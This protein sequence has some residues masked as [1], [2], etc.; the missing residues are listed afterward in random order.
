MVWSEVSNNLASF[1]A[2]VT[3]DGDFT[4]DALVKVGDDE[5]AFSHYWLGKFSGAIR[6]IR[7]ALSHGK[8]LR[9]LRVIAPTK[10]NAQLL[11]PWIG[12]MSVVAR[13]VMLYRGLN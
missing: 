7:N 2:P 5:A 10:R 13:E 4:L 1:T 3:F 8:E 6:G 12:P 11:Q 9:Q